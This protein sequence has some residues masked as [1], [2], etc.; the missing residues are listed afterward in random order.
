M[1]VRNFH[2]EKVGL[3][4]SLITLACC[5]GFGPLLALLSAIGAGFLIHDAILAPLLVLFLLLG[6]IGLWPGRRTHGRVAPLV[7][8]GASAAAIVVFTFV[9]Y[10]QPFIWLGI[11]GLIGASVWDLLLRRQARC[12]IEARCGEAQ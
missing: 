4:G 2:L 1:T 6:A 9:V 8:H 10:V 12:Q 5:L 3:I 7:T 11:A